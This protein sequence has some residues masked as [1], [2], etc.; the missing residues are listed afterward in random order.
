MSR[1]TLKFAIALILGGA[2]AAVWFTPLRQY[3]TKDNIQSFVIHLRGLW[4]GPLAFI[5]IFALS[6]VFALPASVFVIAAG[7][8]WGWAAGGAYSI[9][10][11]LLGA[12]ASFVVGRFM[13][14][15]LLHRFGR[16]GQMVTHQVDHAGF[17]SMLVLR[18]IPGIPFAVLNYGAGVAGVRFVDFFFSTIIGIIPGMFVF[19]WCADSIF[20]GSMTGTD[21]FLRLAGVCALMLAL[22]LLPRAV[23]RFARS[24]PVAEPAAE[25]IE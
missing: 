13:G 23:K 16:A 14:E 18:F 7:Y 20:N 11:G 6:C 5:G 10:G 12:L 22:L 2:F 17:R 4:F 3:V 19:T 15:G 1:R 8:I 9:L 21:A 24:A 25:P